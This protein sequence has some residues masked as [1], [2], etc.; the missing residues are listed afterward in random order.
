MIT[1]QIEIHMKNGTVVRTEEQKVS[2]NLGTLAR[3]ISEAPLVNETRLIE[4]RQYEH[5]GNTIARFET[6]TLVEPVLT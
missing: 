3:Q 2:T 6:G 5:G 4:F 1:F